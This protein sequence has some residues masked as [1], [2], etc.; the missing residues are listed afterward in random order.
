MCILADLFCY[1]CLLTCI[2]RNS[3]FVG[4]ICFPIN[5]IMRLS[6]TCLFLFPLICLRDVPC[7]GNYLG[8]MFLKIDG[9]DSF[10]LSHDWN[11]CHLFF[12]FLITDWGDFTK[13]LA[14]VSLSLPGSIAEMSPWPSHGYA[15]ILNGHYFHLRIL[16]T[17]WILRLFMM[18]WISTCG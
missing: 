11:S 12:F 18:S 10:L 7:V 1:V 5:V 8:N 4:R 14:S 9:P 13:L 3:H 17:S 15:D 2:S 6:A 16:K